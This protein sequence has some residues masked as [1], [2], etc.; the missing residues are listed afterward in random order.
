[1]QKYYQNEPKFNRIYSGNKLPKI[2][3]HFR[4]VTNLVKCKLIGTHWIPFY[5]N[6]NNVIYFDN[7]GTDKKFKRI[8]GNKSIKTNIY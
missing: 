4:N 3:Q 1:M 6:D 5:I 2:N 8:I 7:F